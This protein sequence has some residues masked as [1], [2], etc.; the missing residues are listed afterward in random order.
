LAD[1][2]PILKLI[3]FNFI[4]CGGC[5]KKNSE[6]FPISNMKLRIEKNHKKRKELKNNI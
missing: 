2:T 1:K 6:K 4:S 3:L 5:L